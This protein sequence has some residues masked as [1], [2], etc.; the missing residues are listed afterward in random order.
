M[1]RI[2][3]TEQYFPNRVKFQKKLNGNNK[4]FLKTKNQRQLNETIVTEVNTKQFCN[5]FFNSFFV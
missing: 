2:I 5:Y 4:N 3:F 1:L